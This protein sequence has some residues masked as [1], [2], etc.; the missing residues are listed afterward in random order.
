MQSDETKISLEVLA[1]FFPLPW[2]MPIGFM[3]FCPF[4]FLCLKETHW[5]FSIQLGFLILLSENQHLLLSSPDH[6]TKPRWVQ[7][8][9]GYQNLIA[10]RSLRSLCPLY[11]GGIRA[12][13][14]NPVSQQWGR[15]M[16][17]GIW[18]LIW[19]S[20]CSPKF[21]L[22]MTFTWSFKM[23]VMQSRLSMCHFW[24][25]YSRRVSTEWKLS[26]HKGVQMG[27]DEELKK[28]WWAA[29]L[30]ILTVKSNDNVTM[31]YPLINKKSHV[32]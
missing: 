6:P 3:I 15:C 7:W 19:C 10:M 9:M 20:S 30:I 14:G 17:W 31:N 26:Q 28:W 13:Q 8:A 5:W 29:N 32:T 4:F 24:G 23:W 22:A 27:G 18:F 21:L 2:D 16:D 25:N 1:V 12:A 11:R